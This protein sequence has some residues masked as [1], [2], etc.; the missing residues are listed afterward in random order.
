MNYSCYRQYQQQLLA[1]ESLRSEME[2]VQQKYDQEKHHYNKIKMQMKVK[3]RVR[4]DLGGLTT[5]MVSW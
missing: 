4:Q 3:E 2:G 5:T 1:V